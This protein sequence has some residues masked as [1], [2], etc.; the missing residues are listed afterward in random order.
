MVTKKKKQPKEIDWNFHIVVGYL[1]AMDAEEREELKADMKANGMRVPI[2]MWNDYVIDGRHR[3]E[4]AQELGIPD[5]EILR[6]ARIFEGTEAE[7]IRHAWGLNGLRRNLSS[8]QRAAL[9]VEIGLYADQASKTHVGRK[10]KGEVA[11]GSTAE[12]VAKVVRTSAKYVKNAVAIQK[13]N[14]ELL[15]RVSAGKVEMEE[16]NCELK[17]QEKEKDDVKHT[18]AKASTNGKPHKPTDAC[19]H[20]IPEHLQPVFA[21]LEEFKAIINKLLDCNRLVQKLAETDA[22]VLVDRNRI[23]SE[24]RGVKGE[25][26][27]RRPHTICPHCHGAN[28]GCRECRGNGWITLPML[29]MHPQTMQKKWNLIPI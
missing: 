10:K 5:A 24:I 16:A 7:A 6:K 28:K 25:L 8:S 22:G 15:S 3:L 13:K 9:A 2:E 20:P 27:S 29:K 19:G 17:E 11:T 23:G 18:D 4:V 26:E 12:A 21:Q 14:P 1:P